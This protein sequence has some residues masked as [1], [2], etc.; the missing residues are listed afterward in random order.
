MRKLIGYCCAGDERQLLADYMP[1][2]TPAEHLFH[3]M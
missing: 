1:N 2:D 3:C